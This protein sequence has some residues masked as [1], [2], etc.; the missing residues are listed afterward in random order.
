[1]QMGQSTIS[2]IIFYTNYGYLETE[3]YTFFCNYSSS[4][5]ATVTKIPKVVV[6]GFQNFAL[7][8]MASQQKALAQ[9]TGLNKYK[10]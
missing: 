3:K 7:A 10:L 2:E 1:M 5:L 6:V 8:P 9:T 4:F